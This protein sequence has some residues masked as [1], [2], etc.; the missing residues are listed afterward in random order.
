M[1]NPDMN[2]L[3]DHARI[4]LPGAVDAAILVELFAVL[5]E[6]FIE[7]N[8]WRE[9][10]TF[11][12]QPDPSQLTYDVVPFQGSI[13]R[14]LAVTDK[15]GRP[16]PATMAQPG[17][18]TLGR[19]PAS[20]EE[21]TAHLT[22]TVSDPTTREDQPQFPTWVANRYL[23]TLLDGLLGRM[24]SQ[25]AKPYSSPAIAAVHLRNFRKG[26]SAAR[27]DAKRQNVYGAATWRFPRGFAN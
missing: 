17:C 9:Q 19:S 5:K 7:T 20:P 18:I 1:S 14:L 22:L 23:T 11:T 12:A 27:V 13:V 24:M 10:I 3:L 16:V 26:T 6:F 15:E 4:R 25:I 8:V 2:R 21:Y